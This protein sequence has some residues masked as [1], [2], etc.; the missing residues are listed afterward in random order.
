MTRVVLRGRS[1]A[2]ARALDALRRSIRAGQGAVVAISGE[3]G[4]G[5]SAV[6]RDVVEQ[7][8]RAGFRVGCGKAEQGDQIAPGAPLLVALRSGPRPL[9][10]GEAFAG[11]ASLHD[12][13]LWLIDR[14]AALVEDL[15]ADSPVL[16]AVDDVQWADRL[17]RFAL[18]VLPARLAG[19]PVVWA[20][21]SRT[22]PG[23]ALAEVLAGTGDETSVVDIPLGPLQR[24]DIDALA[25]DRLG[26]AP[27]APTRDILAKVGGN[28]FWAVQ[29][30]D[31]LARR[32]GRAASLYAE[33]A[34]GVRSRLSDFGAAATGLVQLVA[35]WGRPL[36]V[37]DATRMLG[38]S[39]ARLA[40]LRREAAG[41]GLLAGDGVEVSFAH[42]LV[43][44]A[45]YA[46]LAPDEMRTL[47]RTCARHIVGKGESMLCAAAHFHASA[48]KHDE[49]AI[50]ALERASRECEAIPAQAV[51]LAQKAFALTAEGDPIWL[52][53]GERTVEMLV[54]AQREAEALDVADRLLAAAPEPETAASIE[55]QACVALWCAGESAELQRRVEAALKGAGASP[56]L[57]ARLTAVRAL[58]A[59]RTQPRA[60]AEAIARSALDEG[61]RLGDAYAQRMAM[62][63]LVEVARGE[64]RH[65]LALDR[66]NDLRELS[67]TAYLAEE[68]RTLQH[69][70][71]YADAEAMLAKI[72]DA[73]DGNGEQLPSVL[74]ARMWQDHDLGRFEVAEEMARTLL[75]LAE[76]TGNCR[77]QPAAGMVL[78]ALAAYRGERTASAD[79]FG[80]GLEDLARLLDGSDGPLA[81]WL[82]S[83]PWVRIMAA[84]G[85]SA[86]DK[87]LCAEATRMADLAAQRNS[88]V[89]SIE[90]TAKHIH[91]LLGAD[92]GLLSEAVR[93]LRES[94]RP[95]L[96][97]D[98]LKDLG[99]ALLDR[100]RTDDGVRSLTEAAEVYQRLGA[101]AGGRAVSRVLREHG[102]RGVR[103]TPAPRPST[104]WA[105]LTQM[106]SKVVELIIAGRTNRSAAVE[107]GLSPNTVNTHLRAVF[108]KLD[109]KSRVQLTIAARE[110]SAP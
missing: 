36:A 68:I 92:P 45:V 19:S 39:E 9:L 13:P 71:R 96:L 50:L 4:I 99:A 108:R 30:L 59:S 93:V 55:L 80:A 42:D 74:Y 87:S 16:I 91:G 52:R 5:K 51:E 79:D 44:E 11:L 89:A 29:V 103:A 56:M 18:R 34:V 63:S 64:G 109:V 90:G 98:A 65:H 105:S 85:L 43:R 41:N 15:A 83:P 94:P 14:I 95:L 97:A 17:T 60:S 102:I 78:S 48:V 75:R 8:A 24:G 62:V 100:Q 33:L 70:D 47:H 38:V 2:M 73:D 22:V 72:R 31:G 77:Y 7:A 101:V 106:E 40:A 82:W 49:E 23:D 20:V 32:D 54:N 81:P 26:T 58:G 37:A 61:R 6:L 86:G 67:A 3:P 110:R 53:T 76:E 21:T 10:G 57:R 25:A 66:C 84:M 46:A 88:G 28:P 12:K 35:V 107:L 104:G 1:E 69:L 27:S